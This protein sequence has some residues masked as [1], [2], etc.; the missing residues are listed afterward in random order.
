MVTEKDCGHDGGGGRGDLARRIAGGVIFLIFIILLII[1]LV[2]LILRPTKPHFILQDATVYALNVTLPNLLNVTLQITLASRNPNERIGVYY[3]RL[4][5]YASYHNQQVTYATRIPTTY[6]GHK[7]VT[8][9]SPF[10]YGNNVPVDPYLALSLLQ[11]QNAG[12]VQ[13]NIKID[14]RVKWK[15]GTW[16]SSKYHIWVNCPA[17][18]TFGSRSSGISIG[19]GPAMKFQ[20]ASSC[21]A[22]VS[23]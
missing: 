5:V 14:G 6:Q 3:E 15:V 11:D 12:I 17:Y 20:L 23:L 8:V 2:W 1:F 22:E 4:D 7:D 9:W 10:L 16:I 19:P 13:M 21:H 18:L